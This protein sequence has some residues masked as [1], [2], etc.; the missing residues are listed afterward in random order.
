[1]PLLNFCCRVAHYSDLISFLWGNKMPQKTI[2][3]A[4]CS[5]IVSIRANGCLRRCWVK[6][7]FRS[8]Q[9]KR[10]WGR[11]VRGRARSL[12]FSVSSCN[13]PLNC[14]ITCARGITRDSALHLFVYINANESTF[15]Y[16]TMLT[17]T[18]IMYVHEPV[19]SFHS[20]SLSLRKHFRST[21]HRFA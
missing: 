11:T 15:G 1:M 3:P 14:F 20:L 21:I 5:T 2:F 6:L 7:R 19:A 9:R 12:F 17:H 13:S 18:E 4:L 16:K 10:R 8:Q